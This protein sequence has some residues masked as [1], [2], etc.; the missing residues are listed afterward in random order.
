MTPFRD[1]PLRGVAA[2]E[3]HNRLREVVEWVKVAFWKLGRKL[4]G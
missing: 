1:A 2:R 4:G 3:I